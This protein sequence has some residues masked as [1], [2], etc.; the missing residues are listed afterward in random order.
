MVTVGVGVEEMIIVGV[1][2]GVIEVPVLV[3]VC[4][5]EGEVAFAG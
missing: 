5:Q 2:V 1:G 4:D 3:N